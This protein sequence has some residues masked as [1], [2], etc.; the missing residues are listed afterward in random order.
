MWRKLWFNEQIDGTIRNLI[1]SDVVKIDPGTGLL[2][3]SHKAM[4]YDANWL[5]CGYTTSLRDCYL[6]HQIMFRHFGVVPEFCHQ[7]CYKVVV[8]V[9]NFMEA[10]QFYGVMNAS[11]C[12]RGECCNLHGKVGIDERH[13]SSGHFNAFIYCDGLEQGLEKY[14]IVRELVDQNMPDGENIPVILK[15]SCTE[16]ERQFGPTDNDFWK[17]MPKEHVKLQR[18]IEDIFQGEMGSSVQPDWLKN[19][20]I[21]KFIKWANAT[22][23][24]S[25]IE[26]V[27]KDFLTVH[28]YTY[29]HLVDEMDEKQKEIKDNGT[30]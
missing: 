18:H 4:Q 15:R 1:S 20:I 10:M 30:S 2:T 12:I 19:K 8:K 21:L 6:W 26:W 11:G 14:Q 7:R 17:E 27:G 29:H 28:A 5:F 16:F 22:G 23:D 25:W 13:Y 9:R 3:A 24:K